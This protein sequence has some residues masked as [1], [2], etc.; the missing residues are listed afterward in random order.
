MKPRKCMPVLLLLLML[1]SACGGTFPPAGDLGVGEEVK[2]LA[3][4][5]LGKL[6]EHLTDGE[7]RQVMDLLGMLVPLRK[8]REA[9]GSEEPSPREERLVTQLNQLYEDCT[10]RYL[11]DL[12]SWSANE[13]NIEL[14]TEY[15]VKD[16][17][18]KAVE[19]EDAYQD[20]WDQVE[21]MLPQGSLDAFDRFTVFT[22][23]VDEI[24]A[25][26]VPTDD[27]GARWELAVDPQDTGDKGYF[28][29]TVFHE[30]CHYLTL[31]SRQVSYDET[32]A[33]G[34]Y[35]EE[36]MAARPDSY[37][38]TFYQT[39]WKDYL[40]DRRADPESYGFYLRHADDFLTSYAATSPSEDIAESFAYFVLYDKREDEGLQARKQNFFYAYP[41]LVEFRN[42]ARERMGL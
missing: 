31:N 6:E 41:E 1:L 33:R 20:L 38:N 4:V 34:C 28:A 11:G 19:G 42:Q 5:Q 30:Y 36:S 7:R 17:G 26:V 8:L 16:G 18:L 29:E 13:E 14:L 27:N 40:D 25:Y 39:F 35:T 22:D 2:R 23:G 12:G 24:L 21:A 3:S 10:R 32:A 9:E 15:A 37:L